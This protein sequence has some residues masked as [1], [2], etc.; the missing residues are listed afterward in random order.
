MPE[1]AVDANTEDGYKL[2]VIGGTLVTIGALESGA[3]LSQACYSAT[4][5]K[6]SWYGLYADDALAFAFKTPAAGS[7]VVSTAGTA[8]LKSGVSVS[9]STFFEGLGASSASGGSNVTLSAYSA[10]GGMGGPGGQGGP[11]QGGPGF[12]R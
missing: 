11:G 12:G 9:G 8:S 1:V 4:A 3:H 2:Y 7:L 10:A 5:S 6:G